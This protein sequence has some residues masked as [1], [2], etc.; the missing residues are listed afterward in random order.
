[1]CLVTLISAFLHDKLKYLPLIFNFLKKNLNS[2]MY[3]TFRSKTEQLLAA[4]LTR[5]VY[6]SADYWETKT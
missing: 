1:M 3:F 2:I 4:R 5:T 6:C